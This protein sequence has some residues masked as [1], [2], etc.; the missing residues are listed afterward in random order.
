MKLSCQNKELSPHLEREIVEPWQ[1]VMRN[2]YFSS[3]RHALRSV[4]EVL[5][6]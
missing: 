6:V 2:L 3:A 4:P 1:A 5:L